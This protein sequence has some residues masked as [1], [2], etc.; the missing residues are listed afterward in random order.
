M[1]RTILSKLFPPIIT[2]NNVSAVTPPLRAG[3]LLPAPTA[4][5]SPHLG[6][7]RG[8]ARHQ[9]VLQIARHV[10]KVGLA[11]ARFRGGL[12][13]DRG[14]LFFYERVSF[15]PRLLPHDTRSEP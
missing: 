2:I 1:I 3:L 10:A 6:T 11:Q 13:K 4:G 15:C 9:G 8:R 14:D 12:R 7:L 5:R